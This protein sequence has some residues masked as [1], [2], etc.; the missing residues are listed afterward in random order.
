MTDEQ[1]IDILDRRFRRYKQN[2]VD[3]N[4]TRSVFAQAVVLCKAGIPQVRAIEYLMSRFLPTGFL[5]E[6]VIRET[7]NAYNKNRAYFGIERGQYLSYSNYRK[8]K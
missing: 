6:K 3:G 5:K 7:E 2:Y 1:I 8:L 4:R